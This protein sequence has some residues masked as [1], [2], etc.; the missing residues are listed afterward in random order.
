MISLPQVSYYNPAFKPQY[1][2]SVGLP[3]SSVFAQFT[4]NGF[5]Y[6]AAVRKENN[7]MVVDLNAFY[8]SLAKKN[9]INTNLQADLLSVGV[10]AGARL[11]FTFNA[12]A[13]TRTSLML[14]K[15]LFGIVIGGTTPYVNKTASVSPQADVISYLEL[16]TGAAY[17]VNNHLTIGAR[18]KFLKGIA[19]A[20]THRA[21]LD[22]SLSDEY[23][24]TVQANAD[25]RTSG[26]HNLIDGDN[27]DIAESWQDYTQNNG[28][29]IDLGASYRINDRINVSASLIDIGSIR[30]RNDTY[31]YRIDPDK[32]KYTFEGIDLNRMIN[33]DDG[34]MNEVMDSLAA[35]FE[36]V[37]GRISA[38]RTPLPGRLYLSGTYK[39]GKNFTTGALFF[40]EKTRGRFMPGLTLSLNKEFG[41]RIG[42]S[43]TYTITNNAYNNIGAGIAFNFSPLQLYFVGDNLLR[44]PLALA[45][46]NN[47]NGYVNSLQ[48]FSFRAGLNFVFGRVKPQEKQPYPKKS[49]G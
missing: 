13:K 33:D 22:I 44:V 36:P 23:A 32:A 10:K 20:T 29:A 49:Q 8:G 26:I 25:V 14:P 12:T 40:A 30:W 45:T 24:I 2:V 43:L 7:A 3:G 41:R 31:G 15:D 9:Y 47:L 19:N 37:E 39:I 38:Y 6:K 4:N 16:G 5:S 1:K 27:Y 35:N 42:T 46:D 17:T 48:Y 11:Y 34:Y 28:L 21:D 18:I